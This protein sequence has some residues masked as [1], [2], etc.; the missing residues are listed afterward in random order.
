MNWIETCKQA[1]LVECTRVA[2]YFMKNYYKIINFTLPLPSNE[3]GLI[4]G[5]AIMKVY[6]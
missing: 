3:N 5:G 4:K 2:G 1:E 6:E